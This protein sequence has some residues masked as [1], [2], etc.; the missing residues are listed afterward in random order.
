[1]SQQSPHH[2]YP[3]SAVVNKDSAQTPSQRRRRGWAAFEAHLSKDVFQELNITAALVIF[4]M[5]VAKQRCASRFTTAK[6]RK[7]ELAY[8]RCAFL[9]EVLIE[10]ID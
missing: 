6:K 8:L 1:M 4:G 2:Q 5:S 7:K 10:W 3:L 9:V